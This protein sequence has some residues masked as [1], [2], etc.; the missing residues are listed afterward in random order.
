M[1]ATAAVET[2]R[3]SEAIV[4]P[5]QAIQIERDSD[6]A[7]VF[8]EKLGKNGESIRVEVELGL[9]ENGN[10]QIKNGL[11]SGDQVIIRTEPG[12]VDQAGL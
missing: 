11:V 1:T 3:Q 10:T 2:G 6:G 5:N 8:V 7:T 4:V 9:R 12:E